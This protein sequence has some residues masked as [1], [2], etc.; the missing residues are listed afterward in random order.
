M[1]WYLNTGRK[2]LPS[3]PEN[4]VTF[5]GNGQNIVYVDCDNDLV[6][7]VRWIRGGDAL[8]QFIGRVLGSINQRT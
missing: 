3:A 2:P 5:R 1:N 6:I 8:D 4:S 7:V